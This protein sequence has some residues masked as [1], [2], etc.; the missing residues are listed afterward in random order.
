MTPTLQLEWPK[1][2]KKQMT[3]LTGE[4]LK[5]MLGLL[6]RAQFAKLV[7]TL[8][9]DKQIIV[10]TAKTKMTKSGIVVTKIMCH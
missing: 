3:E 1:K 5:L 8:C 2:K 9:F 7:R 6:V 10:D 4:A